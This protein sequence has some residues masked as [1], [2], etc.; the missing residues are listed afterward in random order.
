MDRALKTKQIPDDES[1]IRSEWADAITLYSEDRAADAEPKTIRFYSCQHRQ[2]AAYAVEHRIALGTFRV[3]QMRQYMA[4]RRANGLSEST[5]RHDVVAAKVWFKFLAQ[6]DV[7]SSNPLGA[8]RVPKMV[9]AYV[10]CPSPE[11]L[12][13]LLQALVDR[14]NPRLNPDVQ[15]MPAAVRTFHS[16]RNYAI[17]AGLIE[18]GCRISELLN[19]NLDDFDSIQLQIT[20]RKTK[21]HTHR[22]VPITKEFVTAVES[23]RRIRPRCDSNLLF[24]S[25]TGGQID[26]TTFSRI[27]RGYVAY[28][29]LSG[30]SLHGLRHYAI[31]QIAMKGSVPAAR[32][33]AG[34]ANISTTNRYIHVSADVLREHHTEAAPLR[35]LLQPKRAAKPVRKNL[36]R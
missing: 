9:H 34:H 36:V 29:K 16:R 26:A 19:A 5:L 24:V 4:H 31:S 3:I 33:M 15:H 6:S 7:I 17:V 1:D 35:N 10:K 21:T 32:N 23:W 18:T 28:A 20:F 13:S 11:E 2:L 30:F 25:E 22:T 8:Y 12:K 14:W 27:F